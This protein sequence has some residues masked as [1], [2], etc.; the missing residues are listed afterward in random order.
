MEVVQAAKAVSDIGG[1]YS[2]PDFLQLIV[3][4]KPIT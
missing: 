3:N 4:R 2:R 1:H